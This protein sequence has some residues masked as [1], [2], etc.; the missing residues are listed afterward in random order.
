MLI[1]ML[2]DILFFG[3]GLF[4]EFVELTLLYRGTDHA[5][6]TAKF[7]EIVDGKGKTVHVIKSEHDHVF[8]GVAFETWPANGQQDKHDDKAFLFK[9]H[10]TL[11]KLP[12]KLEL[13]YK[14]YAIRNLKNSL[15]AFGGGCDLRIFGDNL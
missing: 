8:G 7:H 1:L 15:S 14:L 13:K 11:A 12:N 2:G 4:P 6:S 5:F 9:L 3:Y 10:P